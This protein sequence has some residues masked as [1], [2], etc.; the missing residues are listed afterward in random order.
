MLYNSD[1]RHG[2]EFD[3][4]LEAMLILG[5][6]LL[7][8]FNAFQKYIQFIDMVYNLK[9]PRTVS[10]YGLQQWAKTWQGPR[11]EVQFH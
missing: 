9:I 10:L 7:I 6:R 3:C 4:N 5:A 1:L 8:G 11:Y 2:P